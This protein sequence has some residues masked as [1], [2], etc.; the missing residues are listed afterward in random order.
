MR[1]RRHQYF[2]SDMII[3]DENDIYQAM[4]EKM[5]SIKIVLRTP[6][7]RNGMS[8][9]AVFKDALLVIKSTSA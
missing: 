1:Y 4:L 5:L 6:I 7:E 2:L 3:R 9:M 8:G